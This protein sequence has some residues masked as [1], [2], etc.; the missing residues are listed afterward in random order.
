[1][2]AAGCRVASP[3]RAVRVELG[4]AGSQVVRA[5]GD[6]LWEGWG[7]SAPGGQAAVREGP[8]LVPSTL[9]LG[10]ETSSQHS[11]PRGQAQAS[12]AQ[13]GMGLSCSHSALT[14][15]LGLH[16]P[17]L[18]VFF[19]CSHILLTLPS[20][21]PQSLSSLILQLDTFPL[22]FTPYPLL[23]FP[24]PSL[25]PL[26]FALSPSLPQNQALFGTM[27]GN[28]AHCGLFGFL[29]PSVLPQL[30]HPARPSGPQFCQA[31]AQ[32]GWR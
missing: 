12:W 5:L 10:H 16:P 3:R 6:H 15:G 8:P 32:L 25:C 1:M 26:P 14:L 30:T 11:G 22:P 20:F 23:P 7:G 28:R 13:P 2:R 18:F 21:P 27:K 9:V 4:G 29:G 24:P 31:G 19:S 17:A